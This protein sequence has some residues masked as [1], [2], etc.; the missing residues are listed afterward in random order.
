[1]KEKLGALWRRL[2]VKD[3]HVRLWVFLGVAGILLIGISEWFPREKPQA[4]EPAATPTVTQVEQALEQRISRF[5]S[6]VEGVG[7]CQVLVT[8][9]SDAR[10]VYAAV[11]ETEAGTDGSSSS[12]EIL[13]V[14]TETGPTG[15][16]LTTLQ[17]AVKGV[18]VV[19]RGGGDPAIQQRVAELVSTAF[20]ISSRRVYVAAQ[21]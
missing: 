1:M 15:L 19:C 16:L 4:A 6:T 18:A 5:L 2:T 14:A 8:L 21:Q 13:V 3:S 9:E 10:A 7:E 17:P 11:T 20:H 12:E